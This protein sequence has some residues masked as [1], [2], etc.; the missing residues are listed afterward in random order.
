M[1]TLLISGILAVAN[2]KTA[3]V[4]VGPTGDNAFRNNGVWQGLFEAWTAGIFDS[5]TVG[6]HP[7]MNTPNTV[8]G[9]RDGFLETTNRL[10]QDLLQTPGWECK[11]P[12]CAP[13]VMWVDIEPNINI[14][15]GRDANAQC[16]D[17]VPALADYEI[18]A[19]YLSI[20]P[21]AYGGWADGIAANWG[22]D[23]SK[24][25][26]E[27]PFGT[28]TADAAALYDTISAQFPPENLLIVDHWL[29][30][31]MIKSLPSFRTI[32]EPKLD[33]TWS[34]KSIS[35]IV[36]TQYET[37]GL[38]GR[39]GFFDGVGQVRDMI[40]SHLLQ[41]FGLLVV[42][43]D[44]SDKAASKLDIFD[45]ITIKSGDQ[46]QYYG[47]LFEDDL[48]YHPTFA[49]ATLSTITF[50]SSSEQWKNTEIVM[51]TGKLMGMML[52]SIDLY[53]ADGPGKITIDIGAESIGIADIKVSNW[54]LVDSSAF[55]APAPGFDDGETMTMKPSVSESGDGT[56]LSYDTDNLYFPKPYATMLAR[57]IEGDYGTAFVTYPEVHQSW[58]IVTDG[59]ESLY[60]D[61]APETV[62]VYKDPQS[63]GNTPP[64]VCYLDETVQDL[65]DDF[66]CTDE[67]DVTFIDVDFY[68][69]KCHGESRRSLRA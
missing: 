56:V 50:E 6:I 13:E 9:L 42:D 34:D 27:K 24:I 16:E 8:E 61:P 35:K 62:R 21:F 45:D 64:E 14:W 57:I 25:A 22:G 4:L 52:Y 18:I 66:E 7:A 38:E 11:Q 51:T 29:S 48:S 63:C 31:F 68:Q 54:P 58:I 49:D 55:D 19:A 2:A 46:G 17:M 37:R 20:P 10:Y 65:Y 44:T 67:N 3:F 53:Q 41:T 33:M 5:S 43:P 15:E 30:F 60:L 40:Q 36:I 47:W 59:D 1:R 23:R 28:S 26:C 12:D 69:A 39:G 32:L